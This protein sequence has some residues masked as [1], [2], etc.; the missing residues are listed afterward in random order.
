[1][2]RG[3]RLKWTRLSFVLTRPHVSGEQRPCLPLAGGNF[4]ISDPN[5]TT[6]VQSD[7][8][9]PPLGRLHWLEGK[10]F[11]KLGRHTP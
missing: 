10:C 4:C 2:G 7:S 3:G 6:G 11:S 1:M 5:R 9:P 8:P